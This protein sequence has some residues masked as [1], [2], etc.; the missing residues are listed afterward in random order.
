MIYATSYSV[1]DDD[2]KYQIDEKVKKKHFSLILNRKKW[3]KKR[4]N[5]RQR[6]KKEKKCRY[7]PRVH[8]YHI[9]PSPKQYP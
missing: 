6:G 9:I 8:H 3:K 7:S 4:T 1:Y 5:E 2:I